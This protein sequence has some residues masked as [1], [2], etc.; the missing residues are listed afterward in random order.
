VSN[1]W[2]TGDAPGGYR[3]LFELG[4]G[5]MGTAFLARAEGAGGFERLVVIKRIRPEKLEARSIERFLREARLAAAIHHANVVGTQNVGEDASGPFIVLDY[6][7]GA[8]LDELLDRSLLKQQ[9]M[10]VPIV[11][12]I[13][14]DI[15]AGLEA[16]HQLRDGQGVPLNALHRD[17]SLQNVSVGRDGVSRLLDFGIARSDLGGASTDQRYLVGKL[18]YLPPE[19]LKRD[20]LGP[21]GDVYGLGVTVWLALTGQELWPGASEAQFLHHVLHEGIPPL[22]RE[23][24]VAPEIVDLVGKACA[25]TVAARFQSAREMAA[26]IEALGRDRGWLATH[27]EVSEWVD[28]LIGTDLSRRRERIA[29][30]LSASQIRGRGT[31]ADSSQQT[32]RALVPSQR[33][34]VLAFGALAIAVLAVAAWFWAGRAR[35][36]EPPTPSALSPLPPRVPS[37][38]TA[39]SDFHLTVDPPGPPVSAAAPAS[40][41]PAPPAPRQKPIVAPKPTLG[42][43][44]APN[45]ISK[46]NPYRH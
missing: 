2:V 28:G 38:P 29:S 18:P 16:V 22:S 36:S 5:G 14:L 4:K 39:N 21:T 10:P 30:L 7:D 3:V 44:R 40:A 24:R 34:R 41:V 32:E 46:R 12:R 31:D 42:P 6:I 33:G 13:A 23:L 11:L 35:P 17:V 15:L 8:S 43:A 20:K 26:A 1:P 25:G 27:H 9:P 37:E 45:E 19:Y